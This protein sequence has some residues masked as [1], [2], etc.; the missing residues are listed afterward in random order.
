MA[1]SR[2]PHHPSRASAAIA[3][4]RPPISCSTNMAVLQ[5]QHAQLRRTAQ[6]FQRFWW[7][8]CTSTTLLP[9][10]GQVVE[11]LQVNCCRGEL[12]YDFLTIYHARGAI[13]SGIPTLDAA[14]EALQH[15]SVAVGPQTVRFT[16]GRSDSPT[17]KPARKTA[18]GS[19]A[20]REPAGTSTGLFV[21]GPLPRQG[22]SFA[23]VTPMHAWSRYNES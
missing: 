1:S 18:R 10:V 20:A 4:L 17:V 5:L 3:H 2:A 6:N 15:R 14:T 9:V 7:C 21:E 19:T 22:L 12:G 11:N 13:A 16:S 23:M 8:L